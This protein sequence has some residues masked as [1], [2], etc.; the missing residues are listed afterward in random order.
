ML[1]GLPFLAVIAMQ[2]GGSNFTL[3]EGAPMHCMNGLGGCSASASCPYGTVLWGGGVIGDQVKVESTYPSPLNDRW[4]VGFRGAFSEYGIVAHAIAT[5]YAICGQSLPTGFSSSNTA[6]T[7]C[8]PFIAPC[9]IEAF[10]PLENQIVLNGG[11]LGLQAE[12]ESSV[13]GASMP[14]AIWYVS[15]YPDTEDFGDEAYG[16]STA[17]LSCVDAQALNYIAIKPDSPVSC[18]RDGPSCSA[19]VDCPAGMVLIGGGFFGTQS[20]LES[21]GPLS[22]T[23]WFASWY[24]ATAE[25]GTD[26]AGEGTPV[27]MCATGQAIVLVDPIFANGFGS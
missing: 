24:P 7:G 9:S 19:S 21:S 27:A 12:V 6:T 1:I 2:T 25:Y 15:R 22:P 23:T 4:I 10:C 16:I 14:S 20:K 3:V 18:D 5:P 26:A 17:F 13:P 11:I 8:T